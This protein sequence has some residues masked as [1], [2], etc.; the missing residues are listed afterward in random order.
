MW[1]I[2]FPPD[3]LL[4]SLVLRFAELLSNLLCIRGSLG[5][6]GVS[7]RTFSFVIH[8]GRFQDSLCDDVMPRC[9]LPFKRCR[10]R[11]PPVVRRSTFRGSRCARVFFL[12]AM[13]AASLV[14]CA[15]AKQPASM[16]LYD[17]DLSAGIDAAEANSFREEISVG[18]GEKRVPVEIAWTTKRDETERLRVAHLKVSRID[19]AEG[20]VIDPVRHSAIPDCGMKV[21]EEY[22]LKYETAVV[23]LSYKTGIFFE[24]YSFNG[25]VAAVQGNGEFVDLT[26]MQ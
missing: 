7:V 3:L 13:I 15:G 10:M 23:S 16:V 22:S 19:D 17:R 26:R 4:W 20:V 18:P 11:V 24:T 14:G 8:H 5:G 2:S 1:I 25:G 6:S 9:I 21:E 12:A